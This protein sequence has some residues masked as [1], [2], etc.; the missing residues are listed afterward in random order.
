MHGRAEQTR[1]WVASGFERRLRGGVRGALQN[2]GRLAGFDA[3]QG[4]CSFERAADASVSCVIE[5]PSNGRRLKEES[6]L[7]APRGY[8]DEL[9]G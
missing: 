3:T 7:L 9:Q 4:F 1:E 6:F 2:M 5:R 8:A